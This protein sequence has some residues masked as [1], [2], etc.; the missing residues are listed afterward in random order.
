MS[1][2]HYSNGNYEPIKSS[3]P[4]PALLPHMRKA[5]YAWEDSLHHPSIQHSRPECTDVGANTI[6]LKDK[7][8]APMPK[9]P[10]A[11][12]RLLS[13][14]AGGVSLL[15]LDGFAI[16]HYADSVVEAVVIALVTMPTGGFILA[17]ALAIADVSG[18]DTD[19][20]Q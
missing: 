20:M 4:N 16:A 1:T 13:L 15:L 7:I 5:V 8:L 18:E 17:T 2:S 12:P 6:T 11:L 9:K 19:W 10:S 3:N 14:L